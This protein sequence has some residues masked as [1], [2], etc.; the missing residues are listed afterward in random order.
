MDMC[1][2]VSFYWPVKKPYDFTYYC[3][4][5]EISVIKHV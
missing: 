1:M 4:I 3:V 2:C 5:S